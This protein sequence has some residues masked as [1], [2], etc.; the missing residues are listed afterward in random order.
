MWRAGWRL[1]EPG[2]PS[3]RKGSKTVPPAWLT[4]TPNAYIT[5]KL[6]PSATLQTPEPRIGSPS[7]W[8]YLLLTQL[9]RWPLSSV[10]E[11]MPLNHIRQRR[12]TPAKHPSWAHDRC[13]LWWPYGVNSIHKHLL[14]TCYVQ[15]PQP[16]SSFPVAPLLYGSNSCFLPILPKLRVPPQRRIHAALVHAVHPDREPWRPS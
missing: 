3:W 6:G 4:G 14:G 11:Q 13:S 16:R 12:S 7:G 10:P 8:L 1:R 9:H 2:G 15:R 5:L